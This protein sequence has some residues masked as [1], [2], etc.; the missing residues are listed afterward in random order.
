LAGSESSEINSLI[1]SK[2][3]A[4]VFVNPLAGGGRTGSYLL[5]MRELFEQQKVNVDFIVTEDATG[6]EARARAVVDSGHKF[7][8]AMG[9][10]GTFQG[11]VNASY[12]SEV[13]LGV[14]PTGG[15]NDFARALGLPRDPIAAAR[16]VLQGTPRAV[17]LLRVRTADGRERL[18]I[19]GGGVGIDVIAA[20]YAA[21]VFRRVPGRLRYI[22]SVLR[23]LRGFTPVNVR[24]QFPGSAL[25]PMQ[26]RVMLAG[27]L[28]TPSYGAGLRLARDAQIDDG[29]LNIVLVRELNALEIAGVLPALIVRGRIWKR[30]TKH[31]RA[32]KALLLTERA[33][34]FHGDG[35]ILGPT[36]VEIEVLPK[37]ATVLAP[38]R[39]QFSGEKNLRS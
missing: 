12:G 11:L 18:C 22:I 30:F 1:N 10:D 2:A 19:G 21:G 25:P 16:A 23:S 31:T 38:G 37:A 5:R 15:G 26:G 14:L 29:L 35:E 8:L 17:D 7:L 36:P 20:Q 13:V 32:K 3:S 6:L 9:G 4:V 24:V 27:A 39:P 34:F 33:T 28:N